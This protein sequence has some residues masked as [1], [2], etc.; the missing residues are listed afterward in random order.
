MRLKVTVPYMLAGMAG[1]ATLGHSMTSAGNPDDGNRMDSIAQNDTILAADT[2]QWQ[3][4]APYAIE[5]YKHNKDVMYIMNTGDTIR[6]IGGSL[7][8]RNNNPGNLIY[9]DFARAQGAIGKGPRQFAVFPDAATGRAALVA[10]LRSDK[11]NNLTIAN[12]IYKYAPPHENDVELYHNRLRN[13]TGLNL[14]T[15]ICNL[16][17]AQMERVTDAI[18]IIEGWSEGKIEEHPATVKLMASD[19]RAKVIQDNM[20]HTM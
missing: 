7:A 6:R 1:L 19:A 16:D 17:S 8:W 2:I 13:M 3:E 14:N 15:K 11:Y 12:A 18:C 5:A 9:S 10:L 20:S 4:I